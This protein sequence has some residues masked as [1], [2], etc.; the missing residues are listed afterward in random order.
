MDFSVD[1]PVSCRVY[2]I[3]RPSRTY[4]TPLL[5]PRKFLKLLCLLIK[6]EVLLNSVV[7]F[8]ILNGTVLKSLKDCCI[9]FR[10]FKKNFFRGGGG[11]DF[12]KNKF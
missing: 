1:I 8:S 11:G 2:L 7:G 6:L 5:F 3:F 10:D 9:Q 4:S 12:T